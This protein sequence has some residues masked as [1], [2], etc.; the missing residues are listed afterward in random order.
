MTTPPPEASPATPPPPRPLLRSQDDRILAGVSGGLGRWLD[1]DP[2]IFRV[3][4]A[5]LTLFGGVGVIG[6]LIGYL[7]I[8]DEAT[9]EPIVSSRMIPDLRT[10]PHRQRTALGWGLVLLAVVVVGAGYHSTTVVVLLIV[11]AVVA[12]TTRGHL[13]QTSYAT[14]QSRTHP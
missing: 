1:V 9:G 4:F 5:V 14:P 8:P 2:I 3:M 6:Y 13:R 11:A 7:L 10:L 12:L